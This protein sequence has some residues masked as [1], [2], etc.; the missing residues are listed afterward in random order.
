[1]P[2]RQAH[3]RPSRRPR[4]TSRTG[5]HRG[6]TIS[7][8]WRGISGW[9]RSPLPPL[10]RQDA[11][12]DAMVDRVYGE[13][14]PPRRTELAGRAAA[15][16][17]LGPRGA[18]GATL[19]GAAHG[20]Q[21]DPGPGNAGLPRRQYRLSAGGRIPSRTKSRTYA[22]V[23]AYV[24]GFTLSETAL[25]FDT[26]EEAAVI[27]TRGPLPGAAHGIPQHGVVRGERRA[28]PRYSF[29]REFAP[30]LELLL[31][32]IESRRRG[33]PASDPSRGA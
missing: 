21:A 2:P 28:G 12:L 25:P 8:A 14:V 24:Y 23:D 20:V 4:S 18:P 31:D 22:I 9:R 30:G 33:V 5:G 29:A 13:I 16:V 27:V 7:A 32:G 19:G 10:R 17:G 26:G 15:Q 11:L 6:L 3:L 1:M